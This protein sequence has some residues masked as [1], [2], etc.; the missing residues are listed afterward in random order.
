MW[1][2]LSV[3]VHPSAHQQL[4]DDRDREGVESHVD[5]DSGWTPD[6]QQKLLKAESLDLKFYLAAGR[7]EKILQTLTCQKVA[8]GWRAEKTVPSLRC[9]SLPQ[10]NT[11]EEAQSA[12]LLL[13]TAVPS[14]AKSHS[15]SFWLVSLLH[16][17]VRLKVM[18]VTAVCKLTFNWQ[19]SVDNKHMVADFAHADNCSSGG[20]E[21]LQMLEDST[22]LIC[23][24]EGHLGD[25]RLH[26]VAWLF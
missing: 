24:W 4:A 1:S 25:W 23:S 18:T 16:L 8:L 12:S 19:L 6:I 9:S 3:P 17:Q 14:G 22:A 7:P 21:Q 10:F 26:F 20:T 15:A 2:S 11:A 13:P 5:L